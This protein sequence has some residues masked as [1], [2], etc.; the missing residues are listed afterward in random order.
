ML[1]ILELP[2]L[3][4]A[5]SVSVHLGLRHALHMTQ[6]IT[7]EMRCQRLPDGRWAAV[8]GGPGLM[9]AV[10]DIEA[11]TAIIRLSPGIRPA[12]VGL[13]LDAD[14]ELVALVTHPGRRETHVYYPGA[15]RRV[16]RFPSPAQEPDA[17]GDWAGKRTA[18]HAVPSGEFPFQVRLDG[19]AMT[20][21]PVPGLARARQAVVLTG[22]GA[23]VTDADAVTA[24]NGSAV[25][26]SSSADGTVRLWDA[27]ASDAQTSPGETADPSAALTAATTHRDRTLGLVASA[28]EKPVEIVDLGSGEQVARLRNESD[29]TVGGTCA[30]LPGLGDAAV[31]FQQSGYAALW[32]LPAGGLAGIFPTRVSS[33]RTQAGRLPFQSA[34]VALPGRPLAITCGHGSRAIVWDLADGRIH[35]VL[36]GHT[37]AITALAC[38]ANDQGH[39]VAA[40]AGQDNKVN[41]WDVI[42]GR[43]IARFRVV[44]RLTHFRRSESGTAQTVCLTRTEGRFVVLVLCEDGQLH[45]LWRSRRWSRV[46]RVTLYSHGASS[47]AVLRLRDGRLIAMTGA[48]HGQLRAWDVA[49]LLADDTEDEDDD[50]EALLVGIETELS[51]T[52]LTVT[53]D[54]T[55]VA[56]TLTGLAAFRFDTELLARPAAAR[57]ST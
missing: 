32:I 43:R 16:R 1:T 29:W 4:R 39:P 13:R 3:S 26:V 57:A 50:R 24:A 40:T 11:G 17:D 9:T 8:T 51:I 21:L 30:Q 22:H 46:R 23:D 48:P 10:W 2:T 12:R 55:V 56:S 36:R 28:G 6:L 53:G 33:F 47:L 42:S 20:L 5:Q 7:A 31:T 54:D 18:K 15:V 45:L 52:G 19:Q 37:A 49:V 25:L 27:A 38:A 44:K 35:N 34:Q 41:L 14:G